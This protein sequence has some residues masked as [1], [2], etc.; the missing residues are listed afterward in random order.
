MG[1]DPGMRDPESRQ[2]FVEMIHVTR[3]HG[4]IS[5]DPQTILAPEKIP[6]ALDERRYVVTVEIELVPEVLR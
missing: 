5:A 4:R 2:L 6:V 3:E 1:N